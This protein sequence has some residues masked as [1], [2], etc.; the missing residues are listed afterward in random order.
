MELKALKARHAEALGLQP[1]AAST[2]TICRMQSGAIIVFGAMPGLVPATC[3]TRIS[4]PPGTAGEA[5][6]AVRRDHSG[7]PAP[8]R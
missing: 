1:D 4:P 5:A 3:L 7:A 8:R 6:A 2:A